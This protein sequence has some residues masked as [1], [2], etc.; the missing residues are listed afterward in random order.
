MFV[1]RQ[2]GDGEVAV[3]GAGEDSGQAG[4]GGGARAEEDGEAAGGHCW[5]GIY[6][7]M[8]G[9]IGKMKMGGV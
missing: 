8:G 9:L 3:R 5:L 2:E 4:A 6:C 7:W 1:A